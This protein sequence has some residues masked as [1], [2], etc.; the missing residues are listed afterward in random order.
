[1][2]KNM[3]STQSRWTNPFQELSRLQNDFEKLFQDLK[4][5][6][7]IFE[8][9]GSLSPSFELTEDK[10]NYFARFDLPGIKKDE[11]KVELDNNV[12]TVSAERKEEHKSDDKKTHY[13]EISYGS[14]MRSITLPSQVTESKI[15]AKFDS[16]VLTITL[17][18]A[19][20]SRSKTIA[21]Q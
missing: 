13:S 17:P 12:L 11:V 10:N 3:P 6:K 8:S 2:N 5:V 4:P 20:P 14:Y 15:D 21:V 1:M 19:E 7:S 16:G 9:N 18:K